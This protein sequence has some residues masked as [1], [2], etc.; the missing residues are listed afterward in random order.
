M[1]SFDKKKQRPARACDRE[2][3]RT[4]EIVTLK[5]GDTERCGGKIA[6]RRNPVT[7]G[8][9]TQY[10]AATPEDAAAAAAAAGAA[11]PQWSKTGPGLRRSI[12]NKAAEE[13][14]KKQGEIVDAMVRETGATKGW[15]AFNVKLGADI[16]REAAAMTTQLTGETIPSN[17]PGTLSLAIRKPVGPMLGIAPWNAPVILGVRAIAM[18]LACGNSVVLK[19]SEMCPRTHRLIVDALLA[20]G[21]P[22]GVINYINNAPEGAPDIVETLVSHPAI[23]RINFTGSTRIG[24]VIAGLAATEL[25]P[26]LLELG[27]KAPMAVLSDADINEAVKGA[28]F[29]AFFN[30]GQICM[31]TE[32]LIVDDAIGDAFV[33]AF[34][35]R[36]KSITAA[37]PA[38]GDAPLGA[39]VSERTVEHLRELV[40]DAKSKGAHIV[41][42]GAV[43][44]VIM[45]PTIID[46]VTPEMRLWREE[47]FGPVVAITRARG[48]DEI[49]RLANDT[50]YGLSAAVYGADMSR[51]MAVAERIE[52]GICHINGPSVYDE[53]QMPF[54]GVK[55]SGY[56]RFG[57]RFGIEAFTEIRWLTINTQPVQLPI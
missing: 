28:V 13:L 9:A 6:T 56:G 29:G 33:A 18:P 26:V 44:G 41:I 15:S 25:K 43:D 52:S 2:Q 53:P 57:G 27:G 30:Q 11:Y 37:D 35:K 46:N 5:I 12:L 54:G 42:E 31:S 49:V 3:D 45:Q 21:C 39:V 20:A 4:M 8:D 19:G 7:G 55:A 17:R 22:D 40:R 16:L 10:A 34:A 38:L 23:R 14:E 24:K 1:F 32:R 51:L 36:T 50:E 48:D 47:S